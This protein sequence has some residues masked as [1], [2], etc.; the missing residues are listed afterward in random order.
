MVDDETRNKIFEMRDREM[1]IKQIAESLGINAE[2]I[3]RV[4]KK[5]L[6][7]FKN[8]KR[9][10][11][12]RE[13]KRKILE[14]R[15][16]GAKP[17]EIAKILNRSPNAISNFLMR[18]DLKIKRRDWSTIT[19]G[20]KRAVIEK[21][22]EGLSIRKIQ[23]I[24]RLSSSAIAEILK[25]AGLSTSRTNFLDGNKLIRSI[26]K[27]SSSYYI[28]IPSEWIGETTRYVIAKKENNTILVT[29]LEKNIFSANEPDTVIRRAYVFSGRASK[30]INLPSRWY[31][32]FN[33]KKV[34]LKKENDLI[35][36]EPFIDN[37]PSQP[38]QPTQSNRY[39]E[40]I[41][42]LKGELKKKQEENEVLTEKLIQTQKELD[43]LID[44]LE[45]QYKE[46]LD[47]K[48]KFTK[49]LQMKLAEN[50]ILITKEALD[51]LAQQPNANEIVKEI[52]SQQVFKTKIV[53]I[54]DINNLI[55]KQTKKQEEIEDFKKLLDNAANLI[56]NLKVV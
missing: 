10:G 16:K 50:E 3:R 4:L 32:E 46:Q 31:K 40:E 21:R 6:D 43:N 30:Y 28:L 11:L 26:Y 35:K 12:S 20:E 9:L 34:L 27:I 18:H 37:T 25:E 54:E 5:N 48:Q 23:E 36:I 42:R 49:E 8:K 17:K 14:L 33:T 29:P 55:E 1:T 2:I 22:K 39:L 53:E 24:T 7:K 52:L 56:K 45:R 13:E 51:L 15:K 44:Y 41:E 19:E 38:Q 47:K